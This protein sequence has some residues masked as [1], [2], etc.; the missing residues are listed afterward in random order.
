MEH[1]NNTK[2]G[3]G[4]YHKGIIGNEISDEL[5]RNGSETPLHWPELPVG[6][7]VAVQKHSG[8]PGFEQRPWPKQKLTKV[9][10]IILSRHESITIIIIQRKIIQHNNPF[11]VERQIG[12]NRIDC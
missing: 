6:R 9:V 12:E 11:I 2:I 8:Q 10:I 3:R 1:P 4:S 5:E 7:T